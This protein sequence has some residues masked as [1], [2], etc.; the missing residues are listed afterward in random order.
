MGSGESYES[1]HQPEGASSKVD[2]SWF[3]GKGVKNGQ[4]LVDVNCE[5]TLNGA[6]FLHI[7]FL[8]I[9]FGT[10][11]ISVFGTDSTHKL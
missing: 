5:W 2:K 9:F 1:W 6:Q 7:I 3:G 11:A 10:V 4:N 8:K